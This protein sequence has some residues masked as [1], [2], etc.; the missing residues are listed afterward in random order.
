LHGCPASFVRNAN[1]EEYQ[2]VD[3]GVEDWG[4]VIDRM[5]FCFTEMNED[6]CSMK[7]EFA[8]EY[9]KQIYP[10]G[11]QGKRGTADSV[12]EEQYY[13]R[14]KEIVEYRD[15]MKDEGFKLFTEYFWNLWD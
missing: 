4:K 1:G 8:E 9:F 11:W 7:N 3:K 6:V 12:L 15:K 14:E 10:E 13:K 2:D 5:I